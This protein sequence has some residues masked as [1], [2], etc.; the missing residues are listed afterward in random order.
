M[1]K[2]FVEKTIEI[3]APRSK[4]WDALTK[5]EYTDQWALEFSSGGP[6]FH[7][8]SDWKLGSPVLWKGQDDKVI[9]EGNV[10]ALE[11]E[12]LL[13]FTV[14]DVRMENPS[15]T[16]EDGITYKL[17]Q[18]NGKTALHIRQ[19]DFSALDDGEKYRDM[20]AQVWDRVLPKVKKLAET[21]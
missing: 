19:G 17:S 12:E 1:K 11:P 6:Q 20:S 10:T 16:E 3:N 8:E 5:R 18:K 21:Q 2:L 13:R 15:V 7:I 14:F 4:V 9:V